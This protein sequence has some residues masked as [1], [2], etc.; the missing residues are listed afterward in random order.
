MRLA[1]IDC[2]KT[3]LVE[4]LLEYATFCTGVLF[5]AYD[6]AKLVGEGEKAVLTSKMAKMAS[7]WFFARIKI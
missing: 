4:R 5:R 1:L 3:N 7:V 2:Q 6:H